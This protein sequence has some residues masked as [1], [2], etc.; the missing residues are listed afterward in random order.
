M[1]LYGAIVAPFIVLG[2]EHVGVHPMGAVALFVSLAIWPPHFL[3]E[4][5]KEAKKDPLLEHADKDEK[6]VDTE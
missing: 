1:G 3:K 5:F 2:A 6:V 4:T